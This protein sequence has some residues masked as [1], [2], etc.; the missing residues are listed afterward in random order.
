MQNQFAKSRIR[1]PDDYKIS[2]CFANEIK[3]TKKNA[4]VKFDGIV[5]PSFVY[6][7]K[8][9]YV[10]IFPESLYKIEP[11]KFGFEGFWFLLIFVYPFN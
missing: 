8:S 11:V 1:T 9:D 7:F 6:Q 3:G 5:Y 4:P 10:A 2:A